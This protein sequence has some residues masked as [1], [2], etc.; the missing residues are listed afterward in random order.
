MLF[1]GI[2]PA[3]PGNKKE[4]EKLAGPDSAAQY[5]TASEV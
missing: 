3:F 1:D 4:P 2:A 5:A